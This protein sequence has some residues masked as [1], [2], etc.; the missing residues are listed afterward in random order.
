MIALY[1]LNGVPK[2]ELNTDAQI[3]YPS[4]LKFQNALV[5]V[6]MEEFARMENVHVHHISQEQTVNMKMQIAMQV[7]SKDRQS[8]LRSVKKVLSFSSI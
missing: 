8:C 3:S 4:A 6:S 1:K 5:S 2:K 7:L